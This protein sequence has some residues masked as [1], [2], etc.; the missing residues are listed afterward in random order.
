MRQRIRRP[1]CSPLPLIGL[2]LLLS[3]PGGPAAAGGRGETCSS[4]LE[5][6]WMS[7]WE[8]VDPEVE[9]DNECYGFTPISDPGWVR[10]RFDRPP[11][12]VRLSFLFDAGELD[13]APGTVVTVFRL[14]RDGLPLVD[15]ELS[16]STFGPLELGWRFWT[17]VSPSSSASS[18]P[19][20]D[21]FGQI[22]VEWQGSTSPDSATGRVQIDLDG[23]QILN[24]GG[25]PLYQYVPDE[26]LFGLVEV[27]GFGD[28]GFY[29]FK[30]LEWSWQYYRP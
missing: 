11:F 10:E 23:V 15:V 13:L 14:G 12:L 7:Q 1:T 2:A 30:P 18:V 8:H 4:G 24:S 16:R 27:D 20:S 9:E 5:G 25:V 19:L 26:V 6:G 29:R 21:P 17:D 3:V 22:E 28:S